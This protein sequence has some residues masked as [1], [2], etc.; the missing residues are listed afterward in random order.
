MQGRV[1]KDLVLMK[2]KLFW[3]LL[4]LAFFIGG[5]ALISSPPKRPFSETEWKEVEGDRESSLRVPMARDLLSTGQ[6]EGMS[7]S[8]MVALLG[9]PE[10]ENYF[11][12][13]DLMYRLGG[14]GLILKGPSYLAIRL[15]NGQFDHANVLRD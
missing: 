7:K 1:Y 11:K 8:E 2:T 15:E 9:E 14:K 5:A 6:L 10:R 3:V 4:I 13:Y 12:D